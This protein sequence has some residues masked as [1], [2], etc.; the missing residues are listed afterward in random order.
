VKNRVRVF[1][2]ILRI[3]FEP[4][5]LEVTGGWRKLHNEEL[6]TFYSSLSLE[7]K[8]CGACSMHGGNEKFVK[9]IVVGNPEERRPFLRHK[10]CWN[11]YC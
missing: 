11:Q 4:E 10:C 9:K 5:A 7:E 2:K 8:L 6:H 1:D 3:T